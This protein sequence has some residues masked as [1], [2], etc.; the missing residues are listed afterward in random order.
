[1]TG[2]YGH[3]AG[4]CGAKSRALQV[5]PGISKSGTDTDIFTSLGRKD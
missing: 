5:R 3:S 1:M 4:I 2:A